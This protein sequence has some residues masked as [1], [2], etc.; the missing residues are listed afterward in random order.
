MIK[1][2]K[3]KKIDA[4]IANTYSINY[5][6]KENLVLGIKSIPQNKIKLQNVHMIVNK[7]QPLLHSIIE[8]GLKDITE[9]ESNEI[10]NK[11]ISPLIKSK[12]E[13]LNNKTKTIKE[14]LP[15]NELIILVIFFVVIILLLKRIRN[16][17]NNSLIKIILIGLT[18]VFLFIIIVI[19]SMS[20]KNL[21]ER[22]Y[23]N[24]DMSL[25]YILKEINYSINY[26][27]TTKFGILM[28]LNN[29]SELS[30][31]IKNILLKKR[32]THY[33]NFIINNF[34]SEY[35]TIIK[36]KDTNF[37]ILTKDFKTLY[38]F[39]KKRTT[40]IE[41]SDFLKT[42]K[43]KKFLVLPPEKGVSNNF[44]LLLPFY[45]KKVL[46]GYIGLEI[47]PLGDFINIF[48]HGSFSTSGETY[49]FNNK[50]NMISKSRFEDFNDSFLNIA[51]KNPENKELTIAAKSSINKKNGISLN[52]YKDYRGTEVF[53]TWL[54]NDTLNIG[55]VTEIDKE[56]ALGT[57]EEM[58]KIIILIVFS[59]L[60][61]SII[62]VALIM[63]NSI[64]SKN[65]ISKKNLTLNKILNSFD[66]NVIVLRI[67]SSAK[68]IYVSAALCKISGYAKEDLLG[69]KY[70]ILLDP[71][72][73]K[74]SLNK[75]KLAFLKFEEYSGE[76]KFTKK[77]GQIY[78]LKVKLI[79]EKNSNN[80][81]IKIY[82]KTNV[83]LN[84]ISD[85]K[86]VEKL[87]ESLELKIEERTKKV[88]QQNKL[89]TDSIDYASLI[90][91][92]LLPEEELFSKYFKDYFIIW[93]PRDTVGGDIYILEKLSE[94][95]C[96]LMVIDCTGHGVPGAFVTMLVKAIE[97]QIISQ[98]K[99]SKE[100][101]SSSKTLS[102]FNKSTKQLLKQDSKDSLS[103]AGFDGAILHYN[104]KESILKYSGAKVPL[105]FLRNNELEIIKPD[106]H[107]IGY[108]R[109]NIDYAFKEHEI[110]VQEGDCFYLSTDGFKDQLNEE[111]L[112]FGNKKFENMIL[113]NYTNS[114]KSQKEEFINILQEH[115]GMNEKNDDITIVS[116]KI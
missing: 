40:H 55:I 11:W 20:L 51:I 39:H 65:K 6:V 53:G 100:I 25:S 18:T 92:A 109:S 87:S 28:Y 81:I 23:N 15:I 115:M 80:D 108:K 5:L 21:E 63:Y 78:W 3:N 50:G 79:P 41:K 76:I 19:T 116:F 1:A 9:K 102:F 75:I 43:E 58:K 84:D 48:E 56:D 99:E 104:K 54:W 62:L 37:F 17:Y 35:K 42:Q 45:D 68:L 44:N 97:R 93:S 77:N 47:N 88:H 49:A 105:Y 22:E 74:E 113:N 98:Y 95:E 85:K 96:V 16:K 34:I 89:I 10:H 103:N 7:D 57:F 114:C 111:N 8:K 70:T 32:K 4:F 82:E 26:W 36:N 27:T 107:S 31:S 24:I 30:S 71:D 14:T 112:S 38:S 91:H 83:I 29:N 46:L 59:I 86:E 33:E 61:F 64:V 2:L 90:Q 110:K 106:R 101:F 69:R 73:L 52:G 67:D 12:K 66:E 94:D 13:N 60:L 72:N